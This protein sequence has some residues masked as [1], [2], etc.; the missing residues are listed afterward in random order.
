[1]SYPFIGIKDFGVE[2]WDAAAVEKLLRDGV[3]IY[4]D[5]REAYSYY[6]QED[7]KFYFSY[8][9]DDGVEVDKPFENYLELA[10]WLAHFGKNFL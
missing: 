5:D 7:G 9:L 4:E 8:K 3:H 1:M 10:S 6:K 2:K